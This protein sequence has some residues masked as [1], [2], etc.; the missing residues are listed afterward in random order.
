M[1][2]NH[3]LQPF[4]DRLTSRSRL[5][6]TEQQAVLALPTHTAQ[7]GVNRDFVGLGET[8]DHACVVVEGVVGR[9]CQTA[10]GARQIT[11]RHIAGDAPDLHSVV[12]PKDQSALQALSTTTILRIPH[13][14]L[15]TLAAR[16]PA[17]AEAFW[18]DCSVD[19]AVTAQW[20]VNVG[21]HDAR[22]RIAHLLCEMA[23][24]FGAGP[25]EGEVSYSFPLTQAH[26]AD[27][28]GLTPVHVNRTLKALAAEDLVTVSGRTVRIFNW[29]ALAEVGEFDAEYLQADLQPEERLRLVD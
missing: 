16:Y 23:V 24:R 4:L 7:V 6:Q 13:A 1:F 8:V 10:E 18:R 20:V 15:R 27:A 19:A 5:S 21:R 14:A 29:E 22:T 2:Q 3:D 28:T 12:L 17:I 11:A 9:F 25:L 26:L